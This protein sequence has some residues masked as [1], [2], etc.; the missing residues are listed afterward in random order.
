MVYFPATSLLP[1]SS[2]SAQDGPWVPHTAAVTCRNFA[3]T[4]KLQD[5]EDGKVVTLPGNLDTAK[6]K[7]PLSSEGP[8]FHQWVSK[9]SMQRRLQGSFYEDSFLGLFIPHRLSPLHLLFWCFFMLLCLEPFKVQHTKQS[10]A[11]PL[12]CKHKTLARNGFDWSRDVFHLPRSITLSA[13]LRRDLVGRSCNRT[14]LVQLLGKPDENTSTLLKCCCWAV[15]G[16][17]CPSAFVSPQ[18]EW[19]HAAKWRSRFLWGRDGNC[20]PSE[21]RLP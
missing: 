1:H 21:Q 5:L 2:S 7:L 16:I 15:R 18:N 20:H 10:S 12:V 9:R 11:K 14:S 8:D 6:A 4:Y 3:S 19:F 17:R 13:T